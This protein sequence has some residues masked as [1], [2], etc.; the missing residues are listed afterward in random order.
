M[1]I[2]KRTFALLLGLVLAFGLTGCG[3]DTA[4]AE[5]D[6]DA[7]ETVLDLTGEWE[8]AEKASEDSYQ[9]ATING[10]EITVYWYDATTDT[11]SLYWAGTY[12]APTEPGDTYAWTSENDTSKTAGALLSSSDDTK[13]FS[14]ENG[15]ISYEVS[16][17]GTTTTVKLE[18]VGDVEESADYTATTGALP[19]EGDVGDYHVVLTGYDLVTDYDGNN[20]I[21]IN[22]DFTNNSDDTTSAIVALYFQAFQD[23]VELESA[24]TMDSNVCDYGIGQKDIRPGVTLEGCQNAYVLTSDSP[25]EIEVSDIINAP[26]VGATYEVQE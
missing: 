8:Q 24:W 18:R 1:K 22:Y 15:R 19:A 26:T 23:G 21:V 5:D 6:T 2:Q 12:A 4:P 13:E 17:L 25:V 11:K 10:D 14:Y 16:A 20:A 9:V 3:G 7:Q